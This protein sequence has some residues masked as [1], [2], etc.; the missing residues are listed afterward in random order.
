[1]FYS[2]DIRREQ[3][4]DCA[5]LLFPPATRE[6]TRA[7]DA[8]A[9]TVEK[10]GI[11]SKAHRAGVKPKTTKEPKSDHK[12]MSVIDQEIVLTSVLQCIAKVGL[13][14]EAD[15]NEYTQCST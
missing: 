2:R 11:Y 14:V 6:E 9:P 4:I 7:L 12:N 1:M 13:N 3:N 5:L 10:S 15:S 8:E